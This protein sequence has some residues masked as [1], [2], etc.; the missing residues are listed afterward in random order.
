[1]LLLIFTMVRRLT[2]IMPANIILAY[3]NSLLSK[4]ICSKSLHL[5]QA[6][7]VRVTA[8]CVERILEKGVSKI[9][10]PMNRLTNLFNLMVGST[11]PLVE[12]HVQSV[13]WYIVQ[14][15]QNCL[16]QLA[17]NC[18]I[19]E[20][21]KGEKKRRNILK[22]GIVRFVKTLGRR[23][24]H[25]TNN[26][27]ESSLICGIE[28]VLSGTYKNSQLQE[29][30]IKSKNCEPLNFLS[31]ILSNSKFLI[32]CWSRINFHLNKKIKTTLFKNTLYGINIRL[33]IKISNLIKNGQYKFLHFKKIRFNN[34]KK[35]KIPSLNIKRILDKIVIEGIR[36]LLNIIYEPRF[37][38][39]SHS[40]RNNKGYH[41]ALN[42]IK[43][44]FVSI[45]WFIKGEINQQFSSFNH[46]KI[47]DSIK[48]EIQDKVFLDLIYN[49]IKT[50]NVNNSKSI[51]F[52]NV[53]VIQKDSLLVLLNNIYLHLFDEWITKTF[54][55]KYNSVLCQKVEIKNEFF[56]PLVINYKTL[57]SIRYVRY[58]KDFLIG[59]IGSRY[60]CKLIIDKAKQFLQAIQ[61]DLKS[62]TITNACDSVTFLEHDIHLTKIVKQ[63]TQKRNNIKTNDVLFIP[64]INAPMNAI[65]KYLIK[66]NYL[67][68]NGKP[69][70]NGK[71]NHL[72]I[73]NIVKYYKSVQKDILSYYK[74]S[75]NYRHLYAR[76]HHILKYS[77]TLT[78]ANK[79]KLK[80]LNKT[81]KK[82]GKNLSI[83]NDKNQVVESYI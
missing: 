31:Q 41:N 4:D 12:I 43:K 69:T 30:R 15:I 13:N 73:I 58:A 36:Y 16:K 14:R 68:K 5:P 72:S 25:I 78:I 44:N 53:G 76:I 59:V 66:N 21:S 23:R 64:M 74:Y 17:T 20:G 1:M 28:E 45:T 2:I 63:N 77:C 49:Y 62:T 32:E 80:T 26:G 82:Y 29:L 27:K 11:I 7:N 50:K 79:M 52:K 38:R 9:S 83:K 65:I 39:Y 60:E 6:A 56:N 37:L 46:Y 42:D 61:L 81:F 3:K 40:G 47:I 51:L 22:F 24:I 57:E 8:A 18:R 34:I 75:S 48:A 55:T 10:T 71:L 70:K 54:I 35:S 67:K 19:E 33:F